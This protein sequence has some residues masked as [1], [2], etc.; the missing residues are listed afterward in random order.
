MT[1]SRTDKSAE[2]S[3]ASEEADDETIANAEFAV[4]EYI[5]RQLKS[6]F[7]EV[8]AEPIPQSLRSLLEKLER[9][10]SKT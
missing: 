8:A 7:D 10:Q 5:G 6:L 4:H 1:K 2:R 3:I 9:K